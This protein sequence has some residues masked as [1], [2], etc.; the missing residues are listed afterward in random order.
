MFGASLIPVKPAKGT[1]KLKYG[2]V[3]M[4]R[5]ETREGEDAEME[6]TV[7]Q[8]SSQS[9]MEVW[10]LTRFR[11]YKVESISLEPREG[12]FGRISYKPRWRLRIHTSSPPGR[13]SSNTLI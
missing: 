2:N 9:G 7:A 12:L 10:W 6:N 13:G 11:G 3:T 5:N 8:V 1:G 4:S